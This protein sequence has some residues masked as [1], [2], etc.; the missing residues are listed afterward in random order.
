MAVM[1]LSDCNSGRGCL[2]RKCCLTIMLLGNVTFPRNAPRVLSFCRCVGSIVSGAR[3]ANVCLREPLLRLN[4]CF[5]GLIGSTDPE[6]G[7]PQLQ[8][9]ILSNVTGN[10]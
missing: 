7:F 4:Q 6:N 1:K 9:M 2:R 8:E 5:C 10:S 3:R